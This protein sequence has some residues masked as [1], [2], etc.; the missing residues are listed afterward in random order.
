MSPINKQITYQDILD[1]K[2]N[3]TIVD[4]DERSGLQIYCST[5]PDVSGNDMFRG[6]ILF[7]DTI[8][9]QGF[10]YTREIVADVENVSQLEEHIDSPIK[11]CQVFDAYEGVLIRM[12]YFMNKWFI[13]THRRLDAN[14]SKWSS[15]TTYGQMFVNA[16]EN[17][18]LFE[19]DKEESTLDKFK[20]TL[21]TDYQYTFLVENISDNRIVC[22]PTTPKLHHVGTFK[23]GVLDTSIKCLVPYPFS[24]N[25]SSYV[26]LI[27][28]VSKNVDPLKTQGLIIY[29]PNTQIKIMNSEYIEYFKIR[30]NVQSI[31]FRYLQLR[32]ESPEKASKLLSMYPEYKRHF[33]AY[34]NDLYAVSQFILASYVARYVKHELVRVPQGE[35]H[36]MKLCHGKYMDD[37]SKNKVTQE[38]VMRTM[39]TLKP[40]ALNH[41]IKNHRIRVSEYTESLESVEVPIPLNHLMAR[42]SLD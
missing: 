17:L 42:A 16:L 40:T 3:L 38:I 14:R 11:E 31:K 27:E 19:E 33:E 18:N 1:N 13:T 32:V 37:R 39:N 30:D 8:V 29:G 26:E 4:S 22:I 12:F 41:M 10:P 35:F 25:F 2:E 24:H 23:D 7:G 28:Y 6:V 9:S 5:E 21:N 36:V 34:E 20:K 15:S